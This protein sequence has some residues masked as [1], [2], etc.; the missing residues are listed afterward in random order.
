MMRSSVHVAQVLWQLNFSRAQRPYLAMLAADADDPTKPPPRPPGWCPE[1]DDEE[2]EEGDGDGGRGVRGARGNARADADDAEAVHVD[3]DGIGRR[4]IARG[5]VGGSHRRG[6]GYEADPGEMGR[7]LF[8][9]YVNIS[10]I[11][12]R[13]AIR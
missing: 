2:E 1:D 10:I 8:Y 12:L 11:G 5:E 9:G 4:L 3:A 6:I 13:I 7:C